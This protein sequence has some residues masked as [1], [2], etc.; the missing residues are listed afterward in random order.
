MITVPVACLCGSLDCAVLFDRPYDEGSS[1]DF[2]ATTDRYDN[3]GRIVRCRACGL[4]FTDP[5][6][7]AAEI[8]KGYAESSDKEYLEESS[9]RS[10]NAHISLATI[11]RFKPSGK[12]LE[13]GCAVGYFLNAARTDYEVAGVEPGRWAC[14]EARRRFGLEVRQEGFLEARL[15]GNSFDVVAA[16]DVIEHLEDPAAFIRECRRVLKPGGVLYLVTP[17]IESLSARLLGG[18]WW[19]LRPAHLYY[20]SRRTLGELLKREGLETELARSFGRIFSLGYWASRLKNYPAFFRKPV[21][22]VIAAL[23]LEDKI[24]YLNTR[25]SLEVIAR[26]PA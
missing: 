17:D 8:S 23:G 16:V 22:T 6:P 11:R 7:A 13:I 1:S 26:R 25:D 4:V 24:F 10:I 3:Y 9:N 18:S 2:L 21:S 12:L 5:R 15:P 19:G 14:A 20:F